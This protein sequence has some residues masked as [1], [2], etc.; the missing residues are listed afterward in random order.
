MVNMY[1]AISRKLRMEINEN[2]YLESLETDEIGEAWQY[3]MRK[4]FASE[5]KDDKYWEQYDLSIPKSVVKEI[6]YTEAKSVIEKYEW[7]GCMP[8]CVR[9][10]YGLF[11]PP[12][13]GDADWLLG[14]LRYSV[15]NMLKTK[16]FGISMDIR[17]R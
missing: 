13:S 3:K 4:S 17:E 9:H 15:K 8:V 6:T 14:G 16:V 10:C 5:E 2:R 11:F 7:L 1:L 12:L